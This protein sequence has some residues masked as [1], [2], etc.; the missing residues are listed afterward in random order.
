MEV[1]HRHCAGLDVHKASIV[2]CG[3]HLEADGEVKKRVRTFGTTTAELLELSDWLAEEGISHVAME[4]TGVFWKP[5][6]NVLESRF[7]LIL[8]NARHIQNVP[9]RKTDV[10]DCE[11]IAQLLQFGLIRPSFVPERPQREL[12]DLTRQRVALVEDRNRMVNRIHKVLED[13]NIKLGVVA[14]D[15]MG[16]SGRDMIRSLAAGETDPDHLAKLA[17]GRLRGKIP[18]LKLALHGRVNEHH[19]FMLQ[20]LMEQHDNLDKAIEQL[21]SRID[22]MV[23]P[24]EEAIRRLSTIPGVDRLS[25]QLILAEIG[26]DMSRFRTAA[27]IASWAGMCPGNNES[28]GKRK[29]GKTRKGSRW[30][31]RTLTQAAWAASHSKGTYLQAQFRR[32][33]GKRGKKRA[34]IAVGHSILVIIYT[35]LKKQTDFQ[36]LGADYFDRQNP[37]RLTKYLVRRLEKLG[38]EVTLTPA[39]TFA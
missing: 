1:I 31:R 11:W 7:E 39:P 14:T 5:I 3:R 18:E 19:R 6:F 23:R 33:V 15:I 9:G 4:S 8:A 27:H 25:A 13:A 28:A 32:L 38:H 16:V 10:Q 36:D 24:N 17:R 21:V 29:S 20:L 37:V 22:A 34:L 12:R 35:M 26:T 2:A 30:L